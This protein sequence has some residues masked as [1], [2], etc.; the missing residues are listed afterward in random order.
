MRRRCLAKEIGGGELAKLEP[1]QVLHVVEQL[2]VQLGRLLTASIGETAVGQR[3][4]IE[5]VLRR[6]KP[7]HLLYLNRTR[8]N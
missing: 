7:E 8:G 1:R 6:E 4:R 2:A 5:S 3:R